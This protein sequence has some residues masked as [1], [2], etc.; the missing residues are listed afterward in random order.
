MHSGSSPKPGGSHGQLP[1]AIRRDRRQTDRVRA[2]P[3]AGL[4]QRGHLQVAYRVLLE[5]WR[6][7]VDHIRCSPFKC[8]AVAPLYLCMN[9]SSNEIWSCHP[10][11]LTA[12]RALAEA[13]FVTRKPVPEALPAATV[14][15]GLLS[16]VA[17]ERHLLL[18]L[19][20]QERRL[21]KTGRAHPA[22]TS[23]C[24]GA[25]AI[26]CHNQGRFGLVQPAWRSQNAQDQSC[27]RYVKFQFAYLIHLSNLCP[28]G[29][30]EH[31]K[32]SGSPGL[33]AIDEVALQLDPFRCPRMQSSAMQRPLKAGSG[34]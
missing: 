20:P 8:G 31:T 23:P 29:R 26:A 4:R 13:K 12:P 2:R 28:L 24:R 11:C 32:R 30:E 22:G 3:D 25:P 18:A 16:R 15:P 10:E 9:Q 33:P 7:P 21:R 6:Y 27:R 14:T 1:E 19:I 34:M 17:E 5:R